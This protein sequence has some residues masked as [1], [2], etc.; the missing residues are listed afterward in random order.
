MRCQNEKYGR[1]FQEVVINLIPLLEFVEKVLEC[2]IFPTRVWWRWEKENSLTYWVTRHH[3]HHWSGWNEN[4]EKNGAG[5]D[6]NARQ[7]RVLL[8]YL[9]KVIIWKLICEG[10]WGDLCEWQR[11]GNENRRKAAKWSLCGNPVMKRV[12]KSVLKIVEKFMGKGTKIREIKNAARTW[13][14]TEVEVV[15]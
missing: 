3:F 15:V 14:C 11:Q 10:K 2:R 12:E 8:K 6:M 7:R 4:A 5:G 13:C 1:G 9:V